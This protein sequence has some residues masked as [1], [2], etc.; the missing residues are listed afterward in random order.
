VSRKRKPISNLQ[1]LDDQSDYKNNPA[2]W[3]EVHVP[4]IVLENALTNEEDLDLLELS[5]QDRDY[6]KEA[7]LILRERLLDLVAIHVNNNLTLHQ[8]NVVQLVVVQGYTY[9]EA[10]ATLGINYTAVSHALKGIKR[11]EVY[12]GGAE[13][14]LKKLLE[15]DTQYNNIKQMRH[16]LRNHNIDIARWVVEN[17]N[18][19]YIYKDPNVYSKTSRVA[20]KKTNK[21]T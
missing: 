15:N 10:A 11:G 2:H 13:T 19:A 5:Q 8:K 14:K 21:K 7:N 9:N 18:S 6:L 3:R 12:H 4:H 20:T 16:E 1:G 17:E